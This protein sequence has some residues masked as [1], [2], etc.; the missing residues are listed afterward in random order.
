MET[1]V[2]E[3]LRLTAFKSFRDARVPAPPSAGVPTLDSCTS[4]P[5]N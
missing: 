2:V 1:S 3:E 5:Y 4:P